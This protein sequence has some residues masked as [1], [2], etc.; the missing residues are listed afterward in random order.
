MSFIHQYEAMYDTMLELQM[1]LESPIFG[2]SIMFNTYGLLSRDVNDIDVFTCVKPDPL[3][4]DPD[5]KLL[6]DIS[7][8][9][10][11][12]RDI[13]GQPLKRYSFLRREIE[14]CVFVIPEEQHHSELKYCRLF[15][16]F[17][18]CQLPIYGIEAKRQYFEAYDIKKHGEDLV[19]IYR[20]L[21]GL[22]NPNNYARN[23]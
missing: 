14:V 21:A 17:I 15:D 18:R 7:S 20:R 4:K 5:W 22:P 13:F 23:L 12:A 1:T 10:P 2:G 19:E 8:S 11:Y 9:S 16:M 6:N 3:L